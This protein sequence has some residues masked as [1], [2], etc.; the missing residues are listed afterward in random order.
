MLSSI[1]RQELSKEV[2]S[3]ALRRCILIKDGYLSVKLRPDG[4]VDNFYSSKSNK[5]LF[6]VQ[7]VNFYKTQ[8]GVR[9]RDA[10]LEWRIAVL[11]YSVRY[12]SRIFGDVDITQNIYIEKGRSNSYSRSIMLL[13]KGKET[14]KIRIIILNDPTSA[15]IREGYAARG[16]IGVNAF[17][18]GTHIAMDDLEHAH[19][20]RVI[21]SH[22]TPRI[23]FMTRDR[24]IVNDI[25]EK[26][27]LPDNTVGATGQV[28][29]L[30]QHDLELPPLRPAEIKI[31][32]IYNESRLEDAISAFNSSNGNMTCENDSIILFSSSH[33]LDFSLKWAL[34]HIRADTTANLLDLIEIIL[35]SAFSMVRD[36]WSIIDTVKSKQNKKGAIP[37]SL[38]E[39]DGILETALYLS[40]ASIMLRIL[41]DKGK[42]R[43]LYPSLRKAALYLS[44]IAKEGYIK[45]GH[46]AQQGWRRGLPAGYPC[47]IITELNLSVSRALLEFSS[48]A[49]FAGKAQDSVQFREASEKILNYTRRYLIDDNGSIFLNIDCDGTI[50]R[51]ETIDQL[52]SCYRYPFDKSIA[53]SILH[54]TLEKDFESG[55]GPRTVPVSNQAYFSP[56]YC[57]GQLGGYWTRAA[58][59]HS[60]LSYMLGFAGIGS[61]TLLKVANLVYDGVAKMGGVPGEFPYWVNVESRSVEGDGSDPVAASRFIEAIV[62]G[63]LGVSIETNG[64]RIEPPVSS[65]INW[66]MLSGV[67]IGEK[68]SFFIGR[69]GSSMLIA[70]SCK[71]A[72]LVR[73]F[74]FERFNMLESSNQQVKA[75]IFSDP[76]NLIC[77]G[78]SSR[79]IL[80][81][82]ISLRASNIQISQNSIIEEIGTDGNC[83]KHQLPNNLRLNITLLP[84]EW[85]AFRVSK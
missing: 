17:N 54:R 19:E 2:R 13:N 56:D 9:I 67:W 58:I 10:P 24:A 72:E 5:I 32:C 64:I 83:I 61:L 36:P 70:A 3:S 30:V 23:I 31:S 73:G 33:E 80:T 84:N 26:G 52:I 78:N 76:G 18:R 82:A 71:G 79:Q 51:D 21:G 45:V 37:H 46:N 50:H 22:P 75:C 29:V 81:S 35:G 8:A 63:E 47:G 60:I 14:L 85:K 25:I 53:S 57:D 42:I 6:G 74:R 7:S 44:N 43:S 12:T 59:A 62:L 15:V 49:R 11:P 16:S 1:T 77:V 55:Y 65:N 4:R 27:E 69:K 48:L 34:S 39:C 40:N 68:S 20:A 28:L 38:V 41:H 66:L